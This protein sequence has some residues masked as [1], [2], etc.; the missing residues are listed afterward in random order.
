VFTS[1]GTLAAILVSAGLAQ[2]QQTQ[3]S[4]GTVT[5]RVTEATSGSPIEAATVVLVGTPSGAQSAADG[6]FRIT[7]V[8]PGIYQV[9][10]QRI[11]YEPAQS[12]DTE[13]KAGQ[14]VTVNLTLSTQILRLNAVTVAGSSDPTAG[15]KRPYSNA[16]ITAADMPVPS[17][18]SPLQTLAG[19]V[20]GLTV[21]TDG[22]PNG[23][24]QIQLRNPVSYRSSTQPMIIID[25]VIQLDEA[26]AGGAPA[27]P[28]FTVQSSRGFNGNQIE[29]DPQ[30]IESM[31]IVRGAAAAALYGQRAANG[32]IIITTKR[33]GS[34]PTGS[35]QLSFRG[36]AGLS[37]LGKRIP[38]AGRHPFLLNENGQYIDQFGRVTTR[39]GRIADPDGFLD[40]D[41][42]VPV[43]NPIDQFFGV[44]QT[45]SGTGTISQNTLSTTLSVS[46][47]TQSDAGILKMDVGGVENYSTRL[48]V[49][50][51]F[52][53]RLRLTMGASLN[54]RYADLL[55]GGNAAFRAFTDISPDVDI[56]AKDST[57]SYIPFP[58]I[59]QEAEYNP[60]YRAQV[61]DEWEKRAGMQA[62]ADISF[63][64]T[65]WMTLQA[66]FGYQRSD[67]LQRMRFRRQGTI[68][69]DDDGVGQQLSDGEFDI[70]ADL[71]EGANG[72]LRTR[73]LTL[74]GGF[75]LRSDVSVLGTIADVQGFEMEANEME[76]FSPDLDLGQAD[77]FNIDHVFRNT[78]TLSYLATTAIEYNNRYILEGL[79]RYDGNSLLGK[80]SRWQP[81]YRASA[82][83][84]L[85]EEPWWPL[86]DF[87]LFKL[88]YSIGSAGNN[89]LFDDRIER[90]VEDDG[91]LVKDRLGNLE[92]NP[93]EVVEQEIGLDLSF[94]NRFGLELT[95]ARQKTTNAIRED[96]IVAYT[97]FTTQVKNLG[98]IVGQSYEATFEAQWITRPEFQ[99]S[100][101]LI[102]DRARSKIVS[103]PRACRNF[104]ND[105]G[106]EIECEGYVFGEMYG[107]VLMTDWD[108]L[109]IV[110]QV[111]GLGGG[112]SLDQ[113][114]INDEGYLVAVGPGGSWTD[115]KWGTQ[116]SVDGVVYNWGIPIVAS[117]SQ[118]DGQRIS[119]S[120]HRLGQ[121]LP[122]FQFGLQN[123]L[124]WKNWNLFL[125]FTG[126]VGGM[127]YNRTAQRQYNDN[128]HPAMDQFGKP[129]WAK[130]TTNYYNQNQSNWNVSLGGANGSDEINLGTFME[131][132]DYLKIS[133]L[134]L[135]YTFR[136]GFPG[137]RTIGM[138]RGSV[139]IIGRNLYTLTGYSGY[140]PEVGGQRGTRVDATT[141][142]RYRTVSMQ[143]GLTF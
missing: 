112:R 24:S 128:A 76:R 60:L 40:N 5:G 89:P 64:A 90:Y 106:F 51:R 100:S 54:R 134:Q 111:D 17:V 104:G 15:A 39:A 27:R 67:R 52:S 126:Q 69:P 11:G 61:N 118:P 72:Q 25:G 138:R 3:A 87:Q 97:G 143:L 38:L 101:T 16:Q 58:D 1:F 66:L 12:S 9:K 55:P 49:T 26:T 22:G 139:A 19:K 34:V 123:N 7:N 120:V 113:F 8:T 95:Y 32:A 36:E 122:H 88:R 92:L 84:S 86:A 23:E 94:R 110:H 42:T 45:Y 31:E 137:L 129:V 30:D 48:N 119:R 78:R 77:E 29:V 53:D 81:N 73:F 62:N 83:W 75:N 141:Y 10:A 65:P 63:S 33:G 41:W 114:V 121:A 105:L 68:I 57:G 79:Y 50:H 99:W 142:P 102:A 70:G 80:T 108:Q 136:E 98:N 6:S 44:G 93:E 13:V 132:A 43:Y 2:G 96:T 91:R 140:D 127:I 14:V 28:G 109:S 47:G 21:R 82:A 103:Y 46:A 115:Q 124:N 37:T 20:A 85:A 130:K 131:D 4:R 71:D 133:E 56:T 18:G 135:G 35:T 125:Q 116:V 117:L 59:V 74:F 107:N